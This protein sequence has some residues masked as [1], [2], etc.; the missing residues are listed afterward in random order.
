MGG[1]FRPLSTMGKKTPFDRIGLRIER[2]LVS[3]FVV[4]FLFF[5]VTAGRG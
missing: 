3:F 5:R 2:R 1:A 4:L